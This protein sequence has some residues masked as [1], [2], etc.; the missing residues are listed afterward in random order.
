MKLKGINQFEQHVEKIVL[1]VAVLGAAGIGAW[2]FLGAPTV[3][4]SG[5]TSPASPRWR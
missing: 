3:K 2:M 5:T 1:G 4:M